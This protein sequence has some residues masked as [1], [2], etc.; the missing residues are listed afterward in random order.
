MITASVCICFRTRMSY[1]TNPR[2]KETFN[3]RSQLLN[4][5][6]A[7]WNWRI[8]VSLFNHLHCMCDMCVDDTESGA[9]PLVLKCNRTHPSPGS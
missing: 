7:R 2:H 8:G 6:P 1:Y 5:I 3:P 4:F 9:R